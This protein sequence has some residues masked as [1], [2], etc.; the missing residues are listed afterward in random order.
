MANLNIALLSATTSPILGYILDRLIK[1]EIVVQAVI[2]DSKTSTEKEL[3]IWHERTQGHLPLIPLH[4]FE[5]YK[6][7]FYFFC[8]HSSKAT[9]K[10]V[11][12]SEIDLL[13]NAGTLR[14][15]GEDI[16]NAPNIGILNCHPGLLPNFRGC[17]SVEWAIY[18]DEEIGNTVH[19][20]KREID[21]G[22]IIIKEG[23]RFKKSDKYHDVRTKVYLH[24]FELMAKAIKLLNNSKRD[25]RKKEYD[26]NGRY[27][28]VIE[29]D[30]MKVVLD[31]INSGNYLYQ[32]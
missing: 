16:L 28:K 29:E 25:F 3:I 24:G 11:M 30:K 6:I 4:Q 10:F 26:L 20:M 22:P 7:P 1:K 23:L 17:T 9:A 15:L 31:K 8:D 14:I 5:N 21:E 27:F 18:L 32:E 19:L 13:V 12:E 2:F